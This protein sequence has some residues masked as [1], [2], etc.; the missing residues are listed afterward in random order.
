[1]AEH[2]GQAAPIMT[3]LGGRLTCSPP[4]ALEKSVQ[5]EHDPPFQHVIDGTREFMGQD[6]EG[7]ALAVFFL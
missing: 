7:L 1:M 6:R 3:Q 5:I 4:L 2:G